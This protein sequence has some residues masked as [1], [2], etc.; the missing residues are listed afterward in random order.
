MSDSDTNSVPPPS[1]NTSLLT[2]LKNKVQYN[3]YQ[4]LYDPDANKFAEDKQ[5]Q[6]QQEIAQAEDKKAEATAAAEGDPNTFSYKRAAKNALSS[7]LY[8]IAVLIIPFF[9]LMLSMIV[10]NDFIVYPVGARILFFIFVNLIV[11]FVPISGFVIGI[12]YVLKKCY[13]IYYN[14]YN[15]GTREIMPYIFALLPITTKMPTNSL[16]NVLLYPF[17][18]PKSELA[19]EKLPVIMKQYWG[20][21]QESFS[22]LND[23]KG[24]PVFAEGLKKIQT[25]FEELHAAPPE[26]SASTAPENTTNNP[27]QNSNIN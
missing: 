19:R 22:D 14:Y 2:N 9:A 13:S 10:A 20:D 26:P 27:T 25:N 8:W 11:I 15:K 4:A 17:T 18:Y 24:I 23:F 6:Q 21:L 3:L 1:Q 12:F 7:T 16:M 5:K